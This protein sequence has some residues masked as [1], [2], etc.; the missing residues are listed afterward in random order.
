MSMQRLQLSSILCKRRK[1]TTTQQQIWQKQST[2]IRLIP[3]CL[4]PS[5]Q[6]SSSISQLQSL[7]E[8]RKIFLIIMCKKMRRTTLILF[9]RALSTSAWKMKIK[10]EFTELFSFKNLKTQT[11]QEMLADFLQNHLCTTRRNSNQTKLKSKN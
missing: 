2:A 4:Y 10:I 5:H 6:N 11:N 9:L 8:K 7:K 1:E 3:N